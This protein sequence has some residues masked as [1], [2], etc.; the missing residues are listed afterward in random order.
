[1][2]RGHDKELYLVDL[3]TSARPQKTYPVQMAAYD[4]LLRANNINVKGAIL[5]YLDKDGEFPDIDY[6]EDLTEET[7]I[8][9]SALECW[10]YFNKRKKDDKSTRATEESGNH[11]GADDADAELIPENHHDNE[12]A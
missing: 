4:R 5:V 6:L 9:L 3:K 12:R 8:F 7:H 11:T 2:I 1:M 10:H